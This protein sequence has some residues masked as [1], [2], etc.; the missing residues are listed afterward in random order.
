MIQ[1]SKNKEREEQYRFWKMKKN[2]NIYI[3]EC[4]FKIG[5]INIMQKHYDFFCQH[6]QHL[7]SSEKDETG[8][9]T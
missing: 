3:S 7:A 8:A 1:I 6:L 5:T 4:F 2:I 9:D